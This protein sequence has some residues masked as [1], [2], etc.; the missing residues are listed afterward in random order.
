MTGKGDPSP[1]MEVVMAEP[2]MEGCKGA[3]GSGGGDVPRPRRGGDELRELLS[4]L[5]QSGEKE[6]KRGGAVDKT[7]T[8]IVMKVL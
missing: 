2:I 4:G 8:A 1:L 5:L 3:D 7:T 6:A